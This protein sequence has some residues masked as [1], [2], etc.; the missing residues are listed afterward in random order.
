MQ[1]IRNRRKME[2]ALVVI[3][4][5]PTINST[6][7]RPRFPQ[8]SSMCLINK[9]R[10][11]LNLQMELTSINP[12]KTCMGRDIWPPRKTFMRYMKMKG[13]AL[14]SL[15]ATMRTT[16][17]TS[18]S[19]SVCRTSVGRLDRSHLRNQSID[20]LVRS[21]TSLAGLFIP[22]NHMGRLNTSRIRL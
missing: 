4:F 19:R 9:N 2:R 5:K 14:G 3:H 16:I 21:L 17:R 8:P 11:L 10:P 1:P 6:H 12:S 18:S 7:P 22:S 15:R 20:Q 13:Q